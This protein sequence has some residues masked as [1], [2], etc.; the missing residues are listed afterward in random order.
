MPA[1][2]DHTERDAGI[3]AAYKAGKKVE[4][5][6]E[7]FDLDRAS[8]YAI[9]AANG[10]SPT[11][12]QRRRLLAR[13]ATEKAR[14]LSIMLEQLGATC[15][16]LTSDLNAVTLNNLDLATENDQLRRQ[17]AELTARL[18]GGA[19][20]PPSRRKRPQA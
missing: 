1:R 6:E 11:R 8:I 12:Q 3:V 7:T 14:E 18:D 5:M 4:E 17:V 10:I 15:A 19:D 20:Q 16:R 13:D 9:L 2:P